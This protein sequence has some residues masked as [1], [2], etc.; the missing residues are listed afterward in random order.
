MSRFYWIAILMVMATG[1]VA[2]APGTVAA[3][4][5][6]VSI[7]NLMSR[8]SALNSYDQGYCIGYINALLE[9]RSAYDNADR[10]RQTYCIP[11][12]IGSDNLRESFVEWARDNPDR[13]R[14]PALWGFTRSLNDGFPC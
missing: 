3:S 9:Y 4:Q 10:T 12:G 7:D 13:I 5:N 2:V 1:G 14:L 11:R 6:V 8:C